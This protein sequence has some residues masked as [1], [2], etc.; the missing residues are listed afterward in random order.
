MIKQIS[1]AILLTILGGAAM[2]GAINPLTVIPTRGE[3]IQN[4]PTLTDIISEAEG[5]SQNYQR[6]GAGYFPYMGMIYQY[7]LDTEPSPSNI[8]YGTD[9]ST[10]YFHDLMDY[11]ADTFTKANI[12]GD[13]ITIKLPQTLFIEEYSWAEE[14]YYNNLCV[15]SQTGEGENLGFTV[16][17]TITEVTYTIGADGSIT[18]DALPEGKALG[19]MTYF[20]GKVYENPEDEG[21]EDAPYHLE[22]LKA[23]SGAA[24]TQQIF[25]PLAVE[26]IEMPED[27]TPITYYVAI[28]GYN[29]PVDVALKDN[30]IYIRGLGDSPYL[31]N[32]VVRATVDGNKAYIPQ[33]Q[34][35]GI[36]KSDNEMIVTK[37]GYQKGNQIVY[38]EDDVNFEFDYD[39]EKQVLK[40]AD[41]NMY[42]CFAYMNQFDST[43]KNGLLDYY[44]DFSIIYQTDFSGVPSN[45]YGLFWHD[46]FYENYGYHAFGFEIA[47]FSTTGSLLLTGDLYYSIYIDGELEVFEYDPEGLPNSHYFML[48]EAT[49]EIPYLFTNDNDLDIWSETERQVGFYYDGVTT[50][51]VQAVYYYNGKRTV[52]DIVTL[53]LETGEVTKDNAGVDGIYADSEVT[54]IEYFDL[55]GK[56][57][58][59][60]QGGI[61]VKRATLANGKTV[62]SKIMSK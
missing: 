12:D 54:K 55:S 48:P 14:P 49:S 4:Q 41:E 15:L 51:G 36:F 22:W 28:N 59:N 10:V 26:K 32:L 6:Y 34:Y 3:E 47:A 43:G 9:N 5:R 39:V 27:V 52:S 53:N 16:D 37:C 24:D 17:D 56:K 29:Y 57:V 60:P 8:V 62:T 42:L 2:S 33:N 7:N 45:P 46:D 50:M 1:G 31:S 30:Y 40:V 35:V 18:L 20:I 11:G 13:K 38:E 44:K 19:V 61:F 58:S 21:K 25:E 23:W